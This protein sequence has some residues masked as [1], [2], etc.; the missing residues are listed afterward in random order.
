VLKVEGGDLKVNVDSGDQVV[1]VA[2][3]IT[4]TAGT[5]ITLKVGSS[6]ITI[7]SQGIVVDA[8]KSAGEGRGTGGGAGPHDDVK[9]TGILQLQGGLV[10]IG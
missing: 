4:V 5:K 8:P 9:G 6:K 2:Q 7:D 1:D 10:K 3:N